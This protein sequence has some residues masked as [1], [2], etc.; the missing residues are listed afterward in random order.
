MKKEIKVLIVHLQE[1]NKS[2]NQWQEKFWIKLIKENTD[3]QAEAKIQEKMDPNLL[4]DQKREAVQEEM[5]LNLLEDLVE[6]KEEAVQE[7]IEINHHPQEEA[8][9]VEKIDLQ[10]TEETQTE[11]KINHPQEEIQM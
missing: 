4:V 5:E 10:Q 3:H 11:E 8:Q 7:E 6:I 2:S 1:I 9:V